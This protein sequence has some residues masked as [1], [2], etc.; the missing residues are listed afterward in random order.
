MLM[1]PVGIDVDRLDGALLAQPHD[2]ALAE[3]LFDL[4]DGQ[5]DG[6]GAFLLVVTFK[7]HGAPSKAWGIET[8]AG[9]ATGRDSRIVPGE[10]Q[11]KVASALNA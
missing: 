7:R 2:R 11:A 8:P 10:S 5:F 9:P 4:A 3:L 1:A 6:L